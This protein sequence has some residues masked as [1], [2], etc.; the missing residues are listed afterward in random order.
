MVHPRSLQDVRVDDNITGNVEQKVVPVSRPGCVPKSYMHD[1]VHQNE[2]QF[3]IGDLIQKFRIEIDPIAVSCRSP[4]VRIKS[5][6]HMH[7]KQP[8]KPIA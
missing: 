8:E 6:L 5:E 4:D 3:L 2:D 7:Q 1:L